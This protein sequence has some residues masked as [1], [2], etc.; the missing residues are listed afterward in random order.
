MSAAKRLRAGYSLGSG[1]SESVNSPARLHD[2]SWVSIDNLVHILPRETAGLYD[3]LQ[4][5]RPTFFKQGLDG[6]PRWGCGGPFGL[7]GGGVWDLN[8]SS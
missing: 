1:S 7:Y 5:H 4:L 2:V 6:P 8:A 3:V